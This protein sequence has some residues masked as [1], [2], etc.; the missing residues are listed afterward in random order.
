VD[1][2]SAV[3]QVDPVTA[4][5][6]RPSFQVYMDPLRGYPQARHRATR[7]AHL[8]V[9]ADRPLADLHAFA[10]AC[11][12]KRSWFTAHPAHPHYDITA[13]QWERAHHLGATVVSSQELLRLCRRQPLSPRA[14]IFPR[15]I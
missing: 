14:D 12:L 15:T 6:Q 7:W 1:H 10:R 2:L 13:V 11:G 9:A 8:M 5:G 3:Q 4:V